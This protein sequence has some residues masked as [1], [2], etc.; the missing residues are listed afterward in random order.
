MP[1]CVKLHGLLPAPRAPAVISHEPALVYRAGVGT[2]WTDT[3]SRHSSDPQH[4]RCGVGYCTDTQEKAWLPL[5]GIEQSVYRAELRAL[6][7]CQPHEVV[8]DCKGV[9]KEAVQDL[10]TGRRTPTGRN[11]DL[12]KRALNALLS[13]LPGHRIRWM[14][15]H[16]KQAD[17]DFGRITTDDLHG[18][19]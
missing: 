14:E 17:T 11:R 3:S 13:L 1:A 18:N 6:E 7:E 2:V 19:G 9:V 4:R 10:Q 5:P 15:A 8:S 12:E 16:M